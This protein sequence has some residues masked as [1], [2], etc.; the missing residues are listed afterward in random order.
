[1]VLEG[2]GKL[3]LTGFSF[4]IDGNG[5]QYG[6]VVRLLA[7]GAPDPTFG[8]GGLVRITSYDAASRASLT[9]TGKIVTGLVF[10]DAADGV[11][12]SYIV[13]LASQLAAPTVTR[14]G[15]ISPEPT[16]SGQPY[17]VPVSVAAPSGVPDGSV[18]VRDDLGAS[19]T[20]AALSAG[21]GS[22][23]LASS[24][25][26]LRVITAS[27]SGS[28]SFRA[29]SGSRIHGV[30]PAETSTTL[31]S[32]QNPALVGADVALTAT[33]RVSSPGTGVPTGIVTF[34][35]AGAAL[36]RVALDTTARAT[37]TTSALPIGASPIV[38]EYA[39]DASF[40]GSRSA[41]LIQRI[42]PLPTI[43]FSAS[44]AR[45]AETVGSVV[46]AVERVGSSIGPAAVSFSS[47]ADTATAPADYSAVG[48][49]LSWASGDAAA[50]TIV[51]PIVP[52]AVHEPDEFFSVKLT[53]PTGATLGAP[54]TSTVLI[55]R[56]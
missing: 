19:C 53:G 38:A 51:V 39:G 55:K 22:C 27:Y 34:S 29:S 23:M 12:K 45:V 8:T 15:A 54:S 1:M 16:L 36:G 31:A 30:R 47:V 21:T 42:E 13:R 5:L 32:G 14:V 4:D 20:I 44:S 3:V 56:N 43:R 41:P 46:L 24:V 7:G 9:S 49:V 17:S 40:R 2:D 35:R 48:G 50:K 28:P 26:G 52:D 18:L 6:A 10:E 33:V 25:A 11:Q 37:F